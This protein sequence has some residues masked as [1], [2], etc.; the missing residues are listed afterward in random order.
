M[1]DGVDT[2]RGAFEH[3]EAIEPLGLPD[4]DA[5]APPPDADGNS[6]KPP[7]DPEQA[8]RLARCAHLPLNDTGNGARFIEYFGHNALHVPRVGWH[9][10]DETAGT[11]MTMTWPCAAPPKWW[12]RRSWMRRQRLA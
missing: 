12:H 3:A 9:I 5:P 8:E 2:V 10:W 1:I 11:L 4:H 6:P 7:A